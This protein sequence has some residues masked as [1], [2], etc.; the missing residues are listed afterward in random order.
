MVKW[1]MSKRFCVPVVTALMVRWITFRQILLLILT[2][3]VTGVVSPALAA[4][5]SDNSLI[6]ADIILKRQLTALKNMERGRKCTAENAQGGFFNACRD[7]AQR[8]GDIQKQLQ[9]SAA[10]LAKCSGTS[11][12]AVISKPSGQ[13][14]KTQLAKNTNLFG[15]QYSGTPLLFCVRLSDGYYFPAPHSQYARSD[16][17]KETLAQCRFICETPDVN[18]YILSDPA[19]ETADMVSVDK[20]ESYVNLSSAYAYQAS[21]SFQKCNWAK[22]FSYIEQ[23][24]TSSGK[25]RKKT[26]ISEKPV[27]VPVSAPVIEN[28]IS[29][30]T[31]RIVGPAFLQ[32]GND[33]LANLGSRREQPAAGAEVF[34]STE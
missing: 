26:I 16:K 8:R 11:A 7:L 10:A 24:R 21:E 2:L 28:D 19:A 4:T 22:Y 1:R 27:S 18:L 29:D 34:N 12:V 6:A 5:C 3:I 23:V 25:F 30:R 9:K 32:D 31:V 33:R 17:I 13:G 20:R 15:G 14:S